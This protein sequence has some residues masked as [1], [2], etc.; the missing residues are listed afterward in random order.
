VQD[1]KEGKTPARDGERYR[2]IWNGILIWRHLQIID[3]FEEKG[4]LRGSRT[5]R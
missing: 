1:A 3:Y 2:L 4:E 5:L